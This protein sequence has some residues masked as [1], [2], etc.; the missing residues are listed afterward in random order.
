MKPL[1]LASLAAATR[2]SAAS[3][4]NAV[5]NRAA[6]SGLSGG[7]SRVLTRPGIDALAITATAHVG[8]ALPRAAS[9]I[10][11]PS[12]IGQAPHIAPAPAGPAC[13]GAFHEH[14]RGARGGRPKAGNSPG[15]L[16]AR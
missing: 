10:S 8:A 4:R 14:V 9:D 11:R 3:R 16:T 12:L 15:G 7:T 13:A 6:S 5:F 2:V 1:M